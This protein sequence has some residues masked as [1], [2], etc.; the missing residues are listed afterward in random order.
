[1]TD[2]L[3]TVLARLEHTA[4]DFWNVSHENGQFLNF[5]ARTLGAKRILEIGTSNGYSAL[6][7][8]EALQHTNGHLDTIEFDPGRHAEARANVTAADMDDWITLHQGDALQIIP[9][10]DGPYDLVFLDADKPQYLAYAQLALPKLRP[11]GLLIGDD[12]VSLAAQM[13]DYLEFVRSSPDLHTL[14]LT[15]DDGLTLSRKER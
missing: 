15:L 13:G 1:M 6:W 12:T 5:L 3:Q 11:G 7:F 14:D 10:L 2:T 9:T 4:D 8:A